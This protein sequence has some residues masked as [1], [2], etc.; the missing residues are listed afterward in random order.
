VGNLGCEACAP[1][2]GASLPVGDELPHGV[3]SC[4]GSL[5]LD[6]GDLR[7]PA[8]HPEWDDA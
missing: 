6:D 7:L 4:R 1:G 5:P 3:R 2:G 8:H